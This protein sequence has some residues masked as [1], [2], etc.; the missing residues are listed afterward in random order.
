MTTVY[1]LHFDEPLAHARHYVGFA[2]DLDARLACHRAGTGA[3]LLA[4]LRDLGISW[5]L[6]RVWDGADRKFERKLHNTH[7]TA[8]YCPMC[9][10]QPRSYSP[11]A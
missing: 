2:N 10:E 4:V 1:L 11:R 6:A 5:Q 3:R 9:H 7:S 8:D